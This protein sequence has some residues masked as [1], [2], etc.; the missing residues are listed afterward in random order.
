LQKHGAGSR[1]EI[2]IGFRVPDDRDHFVPKTAFDRLSSHLGA[3]CQFK[4]PA[5]VNTTGNLAGM[6]NNLRKVLDK[7][8]AV[9]LHCGGQAESHL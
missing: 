1:Q 8:F 7:H 5:L 4:H 3:F 6:N 2:P 9:S